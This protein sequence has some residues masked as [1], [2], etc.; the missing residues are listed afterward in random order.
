MRNSLRVS[1]RLRPSPGEWLREHLD[2]VE[3]EVAAVRAVQRARLDQ[4]EI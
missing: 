4:A 1:A 2:R 3:Q